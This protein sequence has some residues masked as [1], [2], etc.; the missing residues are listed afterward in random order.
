[1]V[2]LPIAV[3][4]VVEGF[5][6]LEA[7]PGLGNK[8]FGGDVVLV[9]NYPSVKPFVV[10]FFALGFDN[11]HHSMRLLPQEGRSRELISNHI[12]AFFSFKNEILSSLRPI[13]TKRQH[14]VSTP[15]AV[16]TFTVAWVLQRV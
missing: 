8:I 6:F 3:R 15:C 7:I 14:V 16:W 1:M 9:R 11:V 12:S 13:L 4:I 2:Y 10:G 5:V